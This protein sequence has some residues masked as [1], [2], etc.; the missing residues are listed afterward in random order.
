MGR[1]K[2]MT[3][4]VFRCGVE[5][6][7]DSIRAEK[8]LMRR[9]PDLVQREDGNYRCRLDENGHESYRYE[10]VVTADGKPA[11]EVIWT[12][13]PSIV[14]LS[15]FLD[16]D[17]STLFR[18]KNLRETKEELTREDE[19]FC[20]IATRAWGRIE[21]YLTAQTENPKAA[22]GATANLEANFGWKR[23]KEVGLDEQTARVVKESAVLTSSEK[24]EEL[25]KMGL[26]LPWMDELVE[27]EKEMVT[28]DDE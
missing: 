15:L 18:W 6:Y 9:V 26:H 10:P 13:P 24:L 17:R 2:K 21:A 14:A 28:D 7:F 12:Q 11:V 3:A 19:E 4:K 27:A 22:R 16:V 5:A 8:P 25:K 1:K 23:R 20:N